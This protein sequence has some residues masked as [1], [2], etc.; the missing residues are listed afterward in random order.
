MLALKDL[1]ELDEYYYRVCEILHCE[2]EAADVFD[3]GEDR[4]IDV[5]MQHYNQIL[6]T[7]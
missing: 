5:C 6:D 3:T 4:S 2:N 7:V 1:V